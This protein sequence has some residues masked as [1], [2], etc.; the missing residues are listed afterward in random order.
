[1]W[2]CQLFFADNAT[3][4]QVHLLC[5]DDYDKNGYAC[6]WDHL[7][8]DDFG[9]IRTAYLHR[10]YWGVPEWDRSRYRIGDSRCLFAVRCKGG[11]LGFDRITVVFVYGRLLANFT[12]I[13]Q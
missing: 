2:S 7:I 12:S 1:G 9:C 3:C 11:G 13:A 4:N 6:C 5:N 10:W 8:P